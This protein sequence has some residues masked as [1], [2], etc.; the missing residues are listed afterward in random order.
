MCRS[1]IGMRATRLCALAHAVGS[2]FRKRGT[3]RYARTR[4]YVPHWCPYAGFDAAHTDRMNGI[5]SVLAGSLN[6]WINHR[7]GSKG[8]ALA[9]YTLFSMTP[10]LLMAIAIAGYFLG[11][12]AAQGE[13]VAELQ[14][15]VGPN[16]GQAIQALLVG[17]RNPASGFLATIIASVLL[18]AGATTVFVELK[19][20]LDEIWHVE[21]PPPAQRTLPPK[22][23]EHPD[24]TP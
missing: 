19:S 12:K 17:A 4:T 10:I 24:A 23:S 2:D 14:G 8:A 15:L 9:F 16:G 13:I 22:A 18:V 3:C 20:S 7:A 1:S 21:V 6:A 5:A 11:E